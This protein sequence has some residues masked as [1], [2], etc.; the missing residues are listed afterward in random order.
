LVNAPF[1]ALFMVGPSAV[2]IEIAMKRRH[3]RRPSASEA[4]AS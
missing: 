2:L 4:L 3:Q 1:Y